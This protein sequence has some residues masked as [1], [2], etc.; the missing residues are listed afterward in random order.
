MSCRYDI[1]LKNGIVVDY[2]TDREELLTLGLREER[3]SKL[4]LT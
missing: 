2:A 3:L 4:P 1:L